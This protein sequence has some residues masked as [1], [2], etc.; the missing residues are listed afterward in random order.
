MRT[1][2]FYWLTF[3][4]V[5][6]LG[7]CDWVTSE[8]TLT[9]IVLTATSETQFLIVT[10]TFTP[11]PSPVLAPTLPG[12]ETN[13]E[14]T[15][16]SAA[17]STPAT[18]Q[19]PTF[20][21]TPTDTAI[22]P[23]AI[24]APV[25]GIAASGGAAVCTSAPQGG[26][27]TIYTSNPEIAA[28]IG[29]PIGTGSAVPVNNAYQTYE[30]GLMVWVSSAGST[31]Q[32]GIF[33]I[34]SDGTFQR[35][36]DTWRDGIDPVSV[37][38]NPPDGRSEPI[39]GFGKVWRETAGMSEAMGWATGQEIGGSGYVLSFE[40]GEMIY[41]PQTGQ[42]YVLVAGAPGLWTSVAQAY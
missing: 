24:I 6:L 37:G 8:P 22:T 9:P 19:T 4:L 35:F 42:T 18:T 32:P 20:T 14:R 33:A 11:S 27:G 36:N 15:A 13:P 26:F 1:K 38:L 21:P 12:Q 16:T 30:R 28:Q 7:G 31:G 2:L 29:C 23:G 17:T 40:R 39:R 3:S 41:V 25:G 34:F 10:A 5:F